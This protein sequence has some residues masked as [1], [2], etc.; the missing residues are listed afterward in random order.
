MSVKFLQGVKDTNIGDKFEYLRKILLINICYFGRKWMI[1]IL[2]IY[3]SPFSNQI[4]PVLTLISVILRSHKIWKQFWVALS[5][6]YQ[7]PLWDMLKSK[8]SPLFVLYLN[9]V[10]WSL[11]SILRFLVY[12]LGHWPVTQVS[13]VQIPPKS[14]VTYIFT[15]IFEKGT[16]LVRTNPKQVLT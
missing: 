2:V 11:N 1:L 15:E 4:T 7:N 9:T 3:S 8:M 10:I 14:L 12:W 16:F 13:L 5:K 6:L